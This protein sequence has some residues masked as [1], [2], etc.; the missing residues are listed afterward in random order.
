LESGGEVVGC[1]LAIRDVG[2]GWRVAHSD[3][4]LLRGGVPGGTFTCILLVYLGNYPPL[5]MEKLVKALQTVPARRS[6]RP[7]CVVH[8]VGCYGLLRREPQFDLAVLLDPDVLWRRTF[9]LG[10]G[11]R[12]EGVVDHVGVATQLQLCFRKRNACEVIRIVLT[13]ETAH[14]TDLGTWPRPHIPS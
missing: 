4:D 6:S 11:R 12:E 9:A 7:T 2:G 5:A 8:R 1:R 3:D 13:R 10:P 14:A